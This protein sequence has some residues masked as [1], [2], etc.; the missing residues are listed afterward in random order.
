MT[1]A[2]AT[3]VLGFVIGYLGQRARLCFVA[4]YRDGL[5]ARDWTML[6]GVGGALAGAVG[7]FVL[8]GWLGG[9]VPGF[10]Q[11]ANTPQLDQPSAWVITTVAGLAVGF[12]GA[13]AG[14]C[15]FRMHVLAAEGRRTYWFYLLGFY[16]G[17]IFYN[18]VTRTQMQA[19]KALF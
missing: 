4:G 15:P 10:P 6:K 18:L 3:L 16:A 19:L 8:F 7:G 2:I 14:G 13:L 11:L 5:V 12:V 9:T 17:L 1:A